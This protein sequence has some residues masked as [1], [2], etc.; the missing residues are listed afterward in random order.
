MG[1]KC[2]FRATGESIRLNS[3]GKL[4]SFILDVPPGYY[5]NGFSVLLY[6]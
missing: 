5:S 4:L 1:L 6:E 3:A 2:N